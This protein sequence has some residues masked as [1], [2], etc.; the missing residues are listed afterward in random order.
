MFTN[1]RVELFEEDDTEGEDYTEGDNYTAE[2]EDEFEESLS[3]APLL[4]D[5][6]LNHSLWMLTDP[7][8]TQTKRRGRYV[9]KGIR[10][11]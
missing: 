6:T 2:E 4:S 5:C 11:C 3:R 10:V 1:S 7:T 9:S 8:F